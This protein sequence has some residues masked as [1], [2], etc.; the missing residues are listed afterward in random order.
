LVLPVAVGFDLIDEYCAVLAAV[1]GEIALA[2]S[3]DIEP[4]RHAP[5]SHGRFPNRGANHPAL[6]GDLAGEPHIH[7]QQTRHRS[8]PEQL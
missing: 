2:V 5:V 4:P 6:P 3:V 7:R 1:P 8:D